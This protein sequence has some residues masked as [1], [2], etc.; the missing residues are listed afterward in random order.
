MRW[1]K[2]KH[3]RSIK[4]RLW[5]TLPEFRRVKKI[6]ENAAWWQYYHWTCSDRQKRC[7][8]SLRPLPL[9]LSFSPSVNLSSFID[10]IVAR[11]P[12]TPL[13]PPSFKSIS[14][15]Y[16]N[17]TNV[18]SVLFFF[19]CLI[20]PSPLPSRPSAGAPHLKAGSSRTCSIMQVILLLV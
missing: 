7:L 14:V 20:C 1:K 5:P 17:T 15:S 6:K 10:S 4:Y 18:F 19:S 3:W 11:W 8:T 9:Q 16:Q 13:S 2:M 12:L